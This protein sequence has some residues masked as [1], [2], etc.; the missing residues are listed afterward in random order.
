MTTSW[1][2]AQTAMV[3]ADL[4]MDKFHALLIEDK[5]KDAQ[6]YLELPSTKDAIASYY[7]NE[8]YQTLVDEM[9][10]ALTIPF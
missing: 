9:D 1:H 6:D 5:L 10:E 3:Q 8:T 7:G 2:K 4:A